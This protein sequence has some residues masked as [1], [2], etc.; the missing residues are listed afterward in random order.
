MNNIPASKLYRG[1]A[2]KGYD[3]GREKN[4]VT[5]ED[6]KAIM[7]FL[8]SCLPESFIVD[9]PCG[10]GRAAEAVLSRGSLYVGIDISS[11]MLSVCQRKIRGSETAITMQGDATNIPLGDNACDYLLSIKFIKW[12]PTDK[13][14]LVVLKE[15][16]RVCR[17][18]AFINV[19]VIP[20]QR[21][22]TWRGVW[23]YLRKIKD[24]VVLGTVAR[25]IDK[26]VFEGLCRQA[27]WK[28][29]RQMDNPASNGFVCN[30]ILE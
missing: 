30:Y 14:V 22:L 2:A 15:F 28:I 25:A 19:K 7:E 18:Q 20:E 17:G 3:K 1:R 23:D 27:G 29:V 12:L 10:T 9:I 13:L 4:P 21:T 8:Q 26:D 16:R 24:R 6:D 5:V 11:D